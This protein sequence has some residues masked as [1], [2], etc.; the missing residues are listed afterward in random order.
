MLGCVF[1]G[2]MLC[3]CPEPVDD[4]T[5]T[6]LVQLAAFLKNRTGNVPLHLHCM[7]VFDQ[8]VYCVVKV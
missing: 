2:S 6:M 1:V 4:Y 3:H 8:C 5:D 7:A